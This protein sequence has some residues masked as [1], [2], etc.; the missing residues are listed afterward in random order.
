M[1]YQ[2]KI[3]LFQLNGHVVFDAIQLFEMECLCL[4]AYQQ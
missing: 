3:K 2:D 1:L 4:F